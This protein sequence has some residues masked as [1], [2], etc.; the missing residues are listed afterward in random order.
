MSID[1]RGN[2][3]NDLLSNA[4]VSSEPPDLSFIC[5]SQAE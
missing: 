4:F 3:L 2:A 5:L 1:R